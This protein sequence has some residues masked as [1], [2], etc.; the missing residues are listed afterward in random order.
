MGS[1]QNFSKDF[2][3]RKEY[4][5]ESWLCRQKIRT[6]PLK[7]RNVRTLETLEMKEEKG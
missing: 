2:R 1:Y 7:N 4:T 3:G 6:S 5:L